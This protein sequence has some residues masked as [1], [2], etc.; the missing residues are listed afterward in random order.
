MVAEDYPKKLD[1]PSGMD[2]LISDE[3]S[4]EKTYYDPQQTAGWEDG[5]DIG[6]LDFSE[7][8]VESGLEASILGDD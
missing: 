3:Y 5:F 7:K 2:I 6:E 4:D 1:I 8:V